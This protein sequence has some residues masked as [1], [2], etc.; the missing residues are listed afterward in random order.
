MALQRVQWQRLTGPEQVGTV[1]APSFAAGDG[2]TKSTWRASLESSFT[3]ERQG[4][5]SLD[6]LCTFLRQQTGATNEAEDDEG[7][8]EERDETYRRSP[9]SRV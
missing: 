7:A 9:A 2:E 4:F 5:A 6:D 3:A 1:R 8:T